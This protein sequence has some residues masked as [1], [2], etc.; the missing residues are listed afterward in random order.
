M[1]YGLM[2]LIYGAVLF[3]DCRSFHLTVEKKEWRI[4]LVLGLLAVLSAIPAVYWTHLDHA[5][6]SLSGM[7]SQFIS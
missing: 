1:K 3:F 6:A 4:Y 7:F 5:G 2:L